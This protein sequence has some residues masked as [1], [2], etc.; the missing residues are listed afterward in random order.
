MTIKK[1]CLVYL[2]FVFSLKVAS[3]DPVLS[4]RF[5]ENTTFH[6]FEETQDFNEAVHVCSEFDD[7]TTLARISSSSEFRFVAS[8][9]SDVF[10]NNLIADPVNDQGQDIRLW[11]GNYTYSVC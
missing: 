8:M 10:N 4:R 1:R 3:S 5:N 2:L 7:N 9:V 6:V 11:I